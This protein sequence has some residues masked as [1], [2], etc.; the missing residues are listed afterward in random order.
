LFEG[1]DIGGIILYA[2]KIAIFGPAVILIVIAFVKWARGK[3]K[4]DDYYNN[5]KSKK[6][7]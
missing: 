5:V 7:E 1:W 4:F 6:G 2:V 3:G